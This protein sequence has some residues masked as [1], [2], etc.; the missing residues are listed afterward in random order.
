MHYLAQGT[1]IH[2]SIQVD[3]E[4]YSRPADDQQKIASHDTPA[5][6]LG[7]LNCQ[8]PDGC[9]ESDSRCQYRRGRNFCIDWGP[10]KASVLSVLAG[11]ESLSASSILKRLP[12]GAWMSV[13][14]VGVALSK[15]RKDGLVELG[16]YR[17]YRIEEDV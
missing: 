10:R 3:R 12:K 5:E 14:A 11:G 16:R 9:A 2:G 15:L 17:Q 8:V 13:T 4:F 6:Q 1:G 7:C